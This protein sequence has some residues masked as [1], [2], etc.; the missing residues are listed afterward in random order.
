MA[1]E[2]KIKQQAKDD[3][4]KE[5]AK[6]QGSK[7]IDFLEDI[8]GLRADF[9]TY[10]KHKSMDTPELAKYKGDFNKLVEAYTILR[11]SA[12][13]LALNPGESISYKRNKD[14]INKII[15]WHS[16]LEK[17][18]PAPQAKAKLPPPAPSSKNA[19]QMIIDEWDTLTLPTLLYQL[20]PKTYNNMQSLIERLNKKGDPV[21]DKLLLE[22][23]KKYNDDVLKHYGNDA[24]AVVVL[25][26]GL[27]YLA[28]SMGADDYFSS[29]E[30]LSELMPIKKTT[31]TK[32]HSELVMAYHSYRRQQ[33]GQSPKVGEG[34][35]LSKNLYKLKLPNDEM[36]GK[37]RAKKLSKCHCPA[38]YTGMGLCKL[39]F[40]KR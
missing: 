13:G 39:S 5:K 8:R 2:K 33:A 32:T 31:M 25:F 14:T 1:E 38:P 20:D 35:F 37:G 36:K 26:N 6:A 34:Y 22:M 30:D 7:V 29:F 3:K 21:W 40:K 19:H 4:L 11:A 28:K 17:A 18:S 23:T 27:D 9:E 12:V 15:Q 16:K 10:K 24:H